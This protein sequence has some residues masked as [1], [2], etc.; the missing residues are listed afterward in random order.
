[1]LAKSLYQLGIV[2]HLLLTWTLAD[3]IRHSGTDTG[4]HLIF[5]FRE[6]YVRVVLHLGMF[7]PMIVQL[8]TTELYRWISLSKRF[9][10]SIDPT[11][12]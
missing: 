11:V 9:R 3:H 10:T 5:Y 12:C 8:V 4:I 6:R 7:I 1:M 2:I